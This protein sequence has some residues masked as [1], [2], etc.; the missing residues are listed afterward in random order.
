MCLNT[1]L[2]LVGGDTGPY[3]AQAGLSEEWLP[4]VGALVSQRAPSPCTL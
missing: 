3:V 2:S 4:A 1:C